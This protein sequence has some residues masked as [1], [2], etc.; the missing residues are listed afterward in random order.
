M[1]LNELPDREKFDEYRSRIQ[2]F[3]SKKK[4][5]FGGL[6]GAAGDIAAIKKNIETDLNRIK[7]ARQDLDRTLTSLNGKFYIVPNLL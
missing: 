7:Q 5:S 6:L 1:R 3:K 2:Q 4:G